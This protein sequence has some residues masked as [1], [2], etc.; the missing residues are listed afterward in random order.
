M[1]SAGR[2]PTDSANSVSPSNAVCGRRERAR[3][4]EHSERG[5]LPGFGLAEAGVG[6]D[7]ADGRVL[8]RGEALEDGAGR[9]R[10]GR[11]DQPVTVGR[12]ARP[13]DQRSGVGIA[14]V[15][16][17]VHRH[18]GAD[19]DVTEPRR[20][21][22]DAAAH[23]PADAVHLADGG[24]GPGAHVALGDGAGRGAGGGLVAHLPRRPRTAVAE[25]EV[26]QERAG[27][28]RHD[29]RARREA[30]ALRLEPAHHAPD[31]LAAEATAAAEDD[32]VHGRDEVAGIEVVEP[33]DVVRAAPQL[34]AA[35]RRAVAQHDG[36]AGE[37]GRDRSRGRRGCP[38]RR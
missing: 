1:R 37:A 13:G 6:G 17:G 34:D 28:V 24:P 7:D 21:A 36:D 29:G 31:R 16:D 22:A 32:A 27:D 38:G 11:V 26:E 14:H 4:A 10:A 2:S 19:H 15:A 18:E 35:D 9:Q 3:E 25:A 12:L 23:G 33:D 30:A 20:G 5:D 8:G